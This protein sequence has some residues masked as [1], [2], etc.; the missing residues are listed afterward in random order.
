MKLISAPERLYQQAFE[1]SLQANIIFIVS[2]GRIV[3]ANRAACKL[4]GYTK[5][6]LMDKNRNDIFL[7]SED[8]YK[9]MQRDR[10]VVGK[11]KATVS[12]IQKNGKSRPCEISSV[13]FK[14]NEGILNSIMSLGDL[15]IKLLRQ[16]KIDALNEKRVAGDI[17]IAQSK[18]DAQ[19]ADNMDWIQS[20]TANS[21]DVIWNWGIVADLISFGASYERVFGYSLPNYR[22]SFSDWTA[23]FSPREKESLQKRRKSILASD[24]KKWSFSFPFLCP[25]GSPGLVMIRSNILRDFEGKATRMIEVIHDISKLKKLEGLQRSTLVKERQA[26]EAIVDAKEME[27]SD[28]AKELH[29]NINQLL[30]ASLLYLGMARK[31]LKNGDIYL[32]H[33]L[34]YTRTAVD[35]IKKLTR[36]LTEKSEEGFELLPS[37]SKISRDTMESSPVKI[38]STLDPSLEEKLNDKFKLNIF[39]ILQEQLNNILKHARASAI[40]ITLSQTRKDLFLTISDNGIGFD[41]ARKAEGIGIANI[42]SRAALYKG[43]VEFITEPGKGCQLD[44]SFPANNMMFAVAAL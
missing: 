24:K 28:I 32:V 25:D 38:F 12:I 3:T 39:R 21:Y 34:E 44:V 40:Q 29:D 17:I 9:R 13:I 22:I 27:R 10:K 31:D 20:I 41:S 18:S 7:I 37:I 36:G 30:V 8:A 43:Q 2:D 26:I 11:A 1:H 15:K 33:S 42:N 5:K 16:K 35:E 6:E 19:Q 4:L 23:Y 14:D